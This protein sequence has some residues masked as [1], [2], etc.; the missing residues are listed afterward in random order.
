M[1][2]K[3]PNITEKMGHQPSISFYVYLI[4]KY[5]WPHKK[6]KKHTVYLKVKVHDGSKYY[7]TE[8]CPSKILKIFSNYKHL[9]AFLCQIVD[10]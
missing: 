4:S 5:F 1:F 2:I 7:V 8:E 9:K 10:F 3:C 6:K